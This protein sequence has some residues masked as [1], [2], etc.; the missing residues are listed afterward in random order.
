MDIRK[1]NENRIKFI[2]NVFGHCA[3][4]FNH[5]HG[6]NNIEDGT[7]NKGSFFQN[8]E[9]LIDLRDHVV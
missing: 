8:L 2:I 5:H 9:I 7:E 4:L 1:G 6:K 3:D